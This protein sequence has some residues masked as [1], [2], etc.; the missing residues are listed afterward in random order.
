[1]SR[2]N[3]YK[4]RKSRQRREV[5]EGLVKHLVQLERA[6]QPR[7]GGLKLYSMLRDELA[8]ESKPGARSLL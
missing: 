8:A 3:Y 1:M 6:I 5:D 2:Q 7:L 4:A